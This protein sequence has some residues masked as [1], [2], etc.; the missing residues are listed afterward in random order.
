MTTG[1]ARRVRS[2]APGHDPEP[3]RLDAFDRALQARP[4]TTST[5][6]C[7][8]RPPRQHCRRP[9]REDRR[10]PMSLATEPPVA[11]RIHALVYAMQTPLGRSLAYGVRAE[12]E[13]SQLG[14]ADQVVLA[15]G[16]PR[17]RNLARGLVTKRD[18]FS[19]NVPNPLHAPSMQRGNKRRRGRGRRSAR[20]RSS[21]RRARAVAIV[22]VTR[23]ACG[24]SCGAPSRTKSFCM[25]TTSS[26]DRAGSSA[27]GSPS[28]GIAT[29][30]RPRAR[31]TPLPRAP[32]RRDSRP[33]RPAHAAGTRPRRSPAPV[34]GCVGRCE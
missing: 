17:N 18:V 24:T 31:S 19:R 14:E 10:Q 3:D 16:D 27:N 21:G 1:S 2:R 25:S 22:P 29:R 15:L 26:A 34:L 6:K 11:D 13:G 23:R 4:R 12:P 7:G 9:V 28:V 8:R 32:A 20:R 30:A 5:P 33:S